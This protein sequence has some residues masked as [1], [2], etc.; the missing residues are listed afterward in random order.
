MLK[1]D[2]THAPRW[3]DLGRGLRLHVLPP[4]STLAAQ[5]WREMAEAGAFD[6]TPAVDPGVAEAKAWAR[7]VVIGWEGVGD[8]DGNPIEAPS[9]ETIDALIDVP[10]VY[11]AFRARFLAPLHALEQE[12]TPPRPRRV[13][14]PRGAPNTAAL[15][16]GP[17]TTARGS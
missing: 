10:W 11:L 3:L 9:P 8:A 2:L 15:A 1:L 14:I 5:V 4:M 13:G 12:K 7:R 17:A 6:E 16:R